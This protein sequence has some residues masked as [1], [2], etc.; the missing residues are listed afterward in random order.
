MKGA[1]D[2]RLKTVV[3]INRRSLAETTAPDRELRYLDIGAVGRGRLVADPELM[4]F[5]DA[6]SRARRLVL[7]GDTI[8]STVRTYLRAVWPVSGR[9]DDLVVSTGFAVLTPGPRLDPRFLGWAC[10]SDPFIEEVVARSVGVSYPSINGLDLGGIAMPVPSLGAQRAIADYLDAE[11]AR[12]D[13]VIALR[14]EVAGRLVE[15]TT[16]IIAERTAQPADRRLVRVKLGVGRPTSGNRDHSF[17]EDADGVPCLRGLN[18]KPGR[19]D[20]SNLMRISPADH[21]AH[22]ATTL[23]QGDVVV[24]RSGNAGS[25][26]AIPPQLD[27]CN[28]V[29]LIILRQRAN[30]I[31]RY[32]EYSLNSVHVRQQAQA[33]IFGAALTHFNAV[34]LGEIALHLPSAEAQRRVARELDDQTGAIGR[35]LEALVA[36]VKLLQERRQ[37][38]ITAAVTGQLDI[39]GV[40]A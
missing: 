27:G 9:T 4:T 20:T 17:T 16:A 14:R 32:L 24:V 37:T 6:P 18:V 39:P 8:V 1:K 35:S 19:I 34:D 38:L 23:R 33:G 28:C 11:T 25:A 31:P 5:E 29:D 26:A 40:P 12:L 13:E 7:P 30:V 15:R 3:G 36:Q 21:L 10:Q 22:S 2:R